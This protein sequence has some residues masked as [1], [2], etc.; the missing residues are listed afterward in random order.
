VVSQLFL[1][2]VAPARLEAALGAVDEIEAERQRL[3]EQ[4]RL[5][6]ERARY[7]ADLAR[8]RYEEV[9][10]ANR[11]VAATLEADWETQLQN[12]ANLEQEW[13]QAQAGFLVVSRRLCI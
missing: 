3:A 2:A 8:R 11:L 12:L 10:P 13:E 4:W 5:R 6:L 1:Q 7:Q 9:D